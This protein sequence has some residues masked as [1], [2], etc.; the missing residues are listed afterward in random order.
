MGQDVPEAVKKVYV[1]LHKKD[2]GSYALAL[3]ATLVEFIYVIAILDVMPVSYMMGL[4]VIANIFL[5]FLLF[6]CAVK[7]NVYNAKWAVVCLAAAGYMA[8]RGLVI[9][10]LA[11]QPYAR[12]TL[13]LTANLAG[14]A[15]LL[16]AGVGSIRK[17]T[18][19]QKLQQQLQQG[20]GA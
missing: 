17:S 19:R 3:L 15:L 12:Q 8:L 13:L 14:A 5:I 1:T 9:V 2:G 6:T 20:L 4:T 11:L 18:K 7:I 16:A 10:P